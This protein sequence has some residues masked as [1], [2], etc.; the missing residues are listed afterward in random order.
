MWKPQERYCTFMKTTVDP[1]KLNERCFTGRKGLTD[2][3]TG[4]K[5]IWTEKEKG[6]LT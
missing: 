4:E 3:F 5:L 2:C 6:E 1:L